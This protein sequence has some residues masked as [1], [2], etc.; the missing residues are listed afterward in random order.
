MPFCVCVCTCSLFYFKC[1]PPSPINPPP[2]PPISF[3]P[4]WAN[5]GPNRGKMGKCLVSTNKQW[6]N[7]YMTNGYILASWCTNPGPDSK[8]NIEHPLQIS[9]PSSRWWSDAHQSD[10]PHT[11][12]FWPSFP[13]PSLW[14]D[15]LHLRRPQCSLPPPYPPP[16]RFW[17]F[18]AAIGPSNLGRNDVDALWGGKTIKL[19][20]G[21]EEY[22]DWL[23]EEEEEI[24]YYY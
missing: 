23:R 18:H 22:M 8:L 9:R 12:P 1:P 14:P 3:V 17:P 10:W 11:L 15:H 6:H 20:I 16:C 24:Y 21:V 2:S 7:P 5:R 4:Y 19:G 13:H